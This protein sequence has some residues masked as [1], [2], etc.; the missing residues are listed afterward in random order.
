MRVNQRLKQLNI[1][2]YGLSSKFVKINSIFSAIFQFLKLR[3]NL[4]NLVSPCWRVSFLCLSKEKEPKEKTPN[5][6][7]FPARFGKLLSFRRDIH[8]ATSLKCTSCTCANNFPA[9]LGELIWD[10]FGAKSKFMCN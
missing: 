6:S 4:K 10:P 1:S 7:V 9:M 8:V 3:F 5:S 2:S